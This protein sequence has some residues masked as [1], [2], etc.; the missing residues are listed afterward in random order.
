MTDQIAANALKRALRA[1]QAQ[2]GLW[3]TLSS[4]LSAEIIA[5]F[6]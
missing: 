2:I 1:G 5:A 3:S 4:P 6:N